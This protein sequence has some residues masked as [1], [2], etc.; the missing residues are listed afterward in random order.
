MFLVG[1]RRLKEHRE[2]EM[3]SWVLK[4]CLEVLKLRERLPYALTGAQ[5]KVL[6]EVFSDMAGGRVMNRLI[7][8]DVGSGKTIICLLYTSRLWDHL[9]MGQ[10]ADRARAR[11]LKGLRQGSLLPDTYVITLPENGKQISNIC[12]PFSGRV[13]T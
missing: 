12:F 10:N 4:E 8:G 7:Q 9:Y 1:V 5:E 11:I 2:K 6:Q 3:S 13:I